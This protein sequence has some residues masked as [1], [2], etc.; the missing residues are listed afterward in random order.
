MEGYQGL[1][2]GREVLWGHEGQAGVWPEGPPP[3]CSPEPS[4]WPA[5]P[6][7]RSAPCR[8]AP[9]I[10]VWA[11]LSSALTTPSLPGSLRGD[12]GQWV[13]AGRETIRRRM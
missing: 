10:P 3:P 1:E 8:A 2:G 13:C 4:L 6:M 11:P 9:A 5:A 12:E 7:A